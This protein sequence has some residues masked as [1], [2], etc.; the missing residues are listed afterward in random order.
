MAS[1][2]ASQAEEMWRKTP[3]RL[4]EG[5]GVGCTE[6]RNPRISFQ[7]LAYDLALSRALVNI[8]GMILI[9]HSN[10]RGFYDFSGEDR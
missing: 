2:E 6:V 7:H 5:A 8:C 10:S 9:I 1:E 4:Y 3:V